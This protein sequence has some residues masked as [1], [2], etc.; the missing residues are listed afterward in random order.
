LAFL[1]LKQHGL[2]FLDRQQPGYW[3]IK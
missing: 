1:K 3:D 2:Q